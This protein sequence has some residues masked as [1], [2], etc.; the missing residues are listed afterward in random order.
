MKKIGKNINDCVPNFSTCIEWQGGDIACLNIKNGDCLNKVVTII[1]EKVCELAD[2][3]DLSELSLTC[4][5]DKLGATEPASRSL[6]NILQLIIDNECY[7][8]DLIDE[9][10]ESINSGTPPLTLD[11]K[12][13]AQYDSFGNLLPYDTTTVLQS[14][15]NELCDQKQDIT[16]LSGRVT[17]LQLDFDNLDIEPYI[18]PPITTCLFTAKPVSQAVKLLG[19]DYCNYQNAIGLI[20]AIQTAMGL[21]P[22]DFNTYYIAFPGWNNTVTNLSQLNANVQIVLGDLFA[23]IQNIEKNCCALSCDDIKIGFGV[24]FSNNSI[25]LVFTNLYG[26]KIPAPYVDCGSKF[27]I[28][29]EHGAVISGEIPIENNY[30]SEEINLAGLTKG[31]YLTISVNSSFCSDTLTCQ[32]CYTKLIKYETDCCILTNSGAEEVTIIYKIRAN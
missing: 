1:A 18:E 6:L 12:C 11:L 15:I 28:A 16:E 3:L 9:L 25:T 4:L 17:Q 26:T 19:D 13:L 27:T 23:R 31:D 29:D 30:T 10:A 2:P 20:P 14:L 24:I 22:A 7:L 5:V 32:G 21:Q 8:K